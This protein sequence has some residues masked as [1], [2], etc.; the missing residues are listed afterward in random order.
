MKKYFVLLSIY[1]FSFTANAQWFYQNPTIQGQNLYSVKFVDQN[2][3]WA[4]GDGGTILK[5]TDAG[6][7]WMPQTSGTTA[8]LRSA[9]F[10]DQ[11]TGWVVGDGGIV[12]KTT[13]GGTD[14][15]SQIFV[16][17]YPLCSVYFIDQ[18]TGWAVE[19]FGRIFKTAD[20]GIVWT[21]LEATNDGLYSIFF[22]NQ[23]TGWISAAQ[24]RMYKTTDGGT[25][26]TYEYI[27][28]DFAPLSSVQF[29]DENIGCVVGHSGECLKTTNGG[30]NW[31]MQTTKTYSWLQS[32]HF[33]DQNTGWAVGEVGIIIKTTN[34][35]TS[36]DIQTSGI[37]LILNSVYFI[38]ENTGWAVGEGGIILKTTDGGDGMPV[39]LNSFSASLIKDEVI[40][41]WST[42]TEINNYGFEIERNV[43][44]GF[45]NIGFVDGHGNSNSPKNYS[46]T[47]NNP[48]Y[49]KIQYRLKQIDNDGKFEY[50]N[51]IDVNI[52]LPLSFELSQNYP[53]P[54]NPITKIGFQIPG[55]TSGLVSLKVYDILGREVATLINE[56]PPAGIYEVEFNAESLSSGIYFYRLQ[57]GNFVDTKKF[58]LMK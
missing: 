8:Q 2:T 7:N 39:E 24:G 3:G 23:N 31:T 57:T 33:I 19:E 12:L 58:T 6:T 10:I 29:I 36:W 35:G 32:V 38:D 26:W 42:A 1:L 56:E 45:E 44:S 52:D 18:N 27:G 34:G 15:T 22:I 51:I 54:F 37:G 43:K 48:G 11:D 50:S 14:W 30:I 46:F 55:G 9:Y 25:N 28:Y 20:G 16:A 53:N 47:D 4:V 41:N 49:G 5:T 17:S 13:N 40:L 21:L